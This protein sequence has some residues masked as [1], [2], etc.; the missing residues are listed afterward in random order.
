MKVIFNSVGHY[1]PSLLPAKHTV[2]QQVTPLF[3]IPGGRLFWSHTN[4]N[5]HRQVTMATQPLLRS[6]AFGNRLPRPM[7]QVDSDSAVEFI[8][9]WRAGTVM[10]SL[11]WPPASPPPHP[12]PPS[13]T[14]VQQSEHTHRERERRKMMLHSMSHKSIWINVR[15]WF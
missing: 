10:T 15:L 14:P 9:V 6:T 7:W 5:T 3:E 1:D 12:A 13:G 2:T 8:M 4:T 11:G